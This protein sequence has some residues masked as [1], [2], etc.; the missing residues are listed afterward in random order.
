MKNKKILLFTIIVLVFTSFASIYFYKSSSTKDYSSLS[1]L[2]APFSREHSPVIGNIDAK[3]TI[4]EWSDPQCVACKSFHPKVK[5]LLEK[6]PKD[7]KIVIRHLPNHVNSEFMIKILSAAQ[8]QGLYQEVLELMYDYFNII[9]PSSNAKPKF[10][11]TYLNDIKTLDLVKLKKD[12]NKKEYLEN[13]KLDVKDS[14][15][16]GIRVTP[17]FYVNK[18]KL[19]EFSYSALEKLVQSQIKKENK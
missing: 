16:L 18:I 7:I 12:F 2:D 4:I 3:I 11:W 1:S 8:E 5:Q 17:T 9:S 14:N 19:N 13:L 15:T 6:Y 10:I